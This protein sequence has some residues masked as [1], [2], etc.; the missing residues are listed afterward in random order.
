MAGSL[1]GR[2]QHANASA[3]TLRR[4]ERTLVDF[5]RAE[6]LYIETLCGDAVVELD[7]FKVSLTKLAERLE[8]AYRND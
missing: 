7:H 6:G 3:I 2:A 5:F 4:Y 1:T 8:N